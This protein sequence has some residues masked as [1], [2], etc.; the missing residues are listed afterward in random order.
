LSV[1]V[2]VVVFTTHKTDWLAS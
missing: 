1:A 2:N